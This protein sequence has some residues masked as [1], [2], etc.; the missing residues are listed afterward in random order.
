MKR[1]SSL[2]FSRP[3]PIGR[4]WLPLGRFSTLATLSCLP[5]RR[6][7]RRLVLGGPAHGADDVLVPGAAAD[8]AGDSGTDLLLARIG[9]VVEQGARRHQH[10]RRAEAALQGVPLVEPLLDRVERA[11]LRERLD[12]V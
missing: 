1:A 4:S 9:I 2:R 8:R 11:V 12:R 3:K 6:P 10:P 5:S 7:G